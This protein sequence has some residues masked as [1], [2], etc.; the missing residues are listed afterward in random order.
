[1]LRPLKIPGALFAGRSHTSRTTLIVATIGASV[2]TYWVARFFVDELAARSLSVFV[3]AAVFWA[4]ETLPLFATSFVVIGLEIIF[5]A[6]EGGLANQLTDLLAVMGIEARNHQTIKY[7]AFLSPFASD[8]IILF[9]GGFLL[10]AA[11]TKHNIDRAIAR[12]ILR[13]FS[14]SPMALLFG[15]IAITAFFSMWMSNTATTAMMLAIITPV[16][17]R[18]PQDAR[19]RRAL[20]LAVAFGANIGGI[21]TPIGT[22]PNAIAYGAL[23]AAGYHVTFLQWMMVCVPL[24]VV[25]LIVV[26]LVLHFSFRPPRDLVIE[27]LELVQKVTARGWH[28]IKPGAVAL[29]ATAALTSM[30]VLDRHDVDSID[31]NILILMWG[32]LS[33]SV[34]MKESGL[35]QVI[36]QVNLNTLPG[37]GWVIAVVVT[38]VAVLMSTFMSNTA[39][40]SIL[41]PMALAAYLVDKEQYVMLA[42][43]ACSFAMAM[44]VSTP[45]NAMAY[46]T[47]QVPMRSMLRVGA[48]ITIIS[49]FT[50]LMSYKLML[51]IIF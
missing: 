12:R 40:A 22:P 47:G 25:L 17:S 42:A 51:P 2:F 14:G 23:N 27:K 5:L 29:L 1:M 39:T 33:L 13:P 19:F 43:V 16:M 20:V 18:L 6:T 10:S 35:D 34:A 15:V 9:M 45:P 31:W 21:G 49:A 4:T 7:T 48:A 38:A 46:A 32:G 3:I 41:V 11:L 30:A 24:E 8:I 36:A 26:G 50:M 28:G 37:G 44:P